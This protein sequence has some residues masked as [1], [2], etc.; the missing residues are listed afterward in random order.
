MQDTTLWLSFNV[1]ALLRQTPCSFSEGLD[2]YYYVVGAQQSAE[3]SDTYV[4]LALICVG[5]Y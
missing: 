4:L 5:K 3:H 2:Y 1:R